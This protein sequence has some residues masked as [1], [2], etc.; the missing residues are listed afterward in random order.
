MHAWRRA[1]FCHW[2]VPTYVTS[3]GK[4]VA[5]QANFTSLATPSAPGSGHTIVKLTP[6]E[7]AAWKDS[8]RPVY[9]SWGED[10]RKAGYDGDK[11]LA[12]LKAAL[13]KHGAL[14]E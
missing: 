5:S 2:P 4:R 9:A 6:Q 13:S 8:T 7:L 11:V 12:D 1:G 14:A 10:M 3:G